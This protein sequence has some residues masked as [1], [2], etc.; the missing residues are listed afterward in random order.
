MA[1]DKTQLPKYNNSGATV[2]AGLVLAFAPIDI[3]GDPLGVRFAVVMAGINNQVVTNV[4]PPSVVA[5]MARKPVP[6]DFHRI[7]ASGNISHVPA[8][9]FKASHTLL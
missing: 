2:N 9:T 6:G 1:F 7:D 4:V 3:D 5:T 8:A